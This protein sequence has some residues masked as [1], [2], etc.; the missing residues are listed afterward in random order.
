MEYVRR[1]IAEANNAFRTADH[2]A[3]VSYPILKDNRLL[4]AITQNL[5]IAGLKGM[6]AVLYYEY[7]HKRISHMPFDFDSR[8]LI[9][10]RIAPRMKIKS[11]I[12][13]TIREL[14]FVMNEHK[15]SSVEF[16]RRDNFV[17]CSDN[18]TT[19]QVVNIETVKNNLNNIKEFLFACNSLCK[20]V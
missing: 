2:L 9:F 8:L 1:A 19:L 7:L 20:N 10:E 13:R 5:Y 12:C 6:D 14:R 15:T 11:E 3:Y 16:S 18:Y 4:M 17:I